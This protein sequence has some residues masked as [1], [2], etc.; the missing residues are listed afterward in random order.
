VFSNRAVE[1]VAL[2][3]RTCSLIS[4]STLCTIS[5]TSDLSDLPTIWLGQLL[6]EH[7]IWSLG[8]SNRAAIYAQEAALASS[9]IFAWSVVLQV[10]VDKLASSKGRQER[11]LTSEHAASDNGSQKL[12]ICPRR[13]TI[14]TPNTEQVQTRGL[15]GKTSATSNSTY[16]RKIW[17]VVT[18]K[19]Y[20]DRL[21]I[22][23]TAPKRS[24]MEGSFGWWFHNS[25]GTVY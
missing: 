8:G 7:V 9:N 24:S 25:S 20:Y 14:R 21:L 23:N 2:V 3:V 22:Q 12:S 15:W 5:L 19:G 11:E 18:R 1:Q 10:A 17:T 13:V 6:S 4:S 16:L